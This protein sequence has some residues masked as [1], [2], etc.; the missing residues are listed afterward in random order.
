MSHALCRGC[1][2]RNEQKRDGLYGLCPHG[3]FSTDPKIKQRAKMLKNK[4]ISESLRIKEREKYN[5]VKVKT[6]GKDE[7]FWG[8]GTSKSQCI[9]KPNSSNSELPRLDFRSP[10]L[11]S[12]GN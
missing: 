2:Y 4:D 9:K 1:G 7:L 6:G 11:C 10:G 5:M 8:K 3:N 12:L